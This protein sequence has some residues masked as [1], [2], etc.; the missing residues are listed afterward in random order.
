M[1]EMLWKWI[2]AAVIVADAEGMPDSEVIPTWP[3][4]PTEQ[5]VE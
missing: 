1:S 4:P 2:E 3:E 5:E